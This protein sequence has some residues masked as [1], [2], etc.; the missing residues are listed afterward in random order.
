MCSAAFHH[1]G[2][3]RGY[4]INTGIKVL[5]EPGDMTVNVATQNQAAADADLADP[6]LVKLRDLIY[7]VSGIFHAESKFYLLA[8]RARRRMKELSCN[9]FADYVDQLTTRA[10]RDAEMRNL[11]NEITI[12]ETYFFRGQPTIDAVSKIIFPRIVSQPSKQVIKKLRI[13]SAGC[14]TGEESYTLSILF[15]EQIAPKFKDWKIEIL[16]TDLND[17][18]LAKCREGRYGEYSVRNLSPLMRDKYFKQEG[19]LYRVNEIVRAPIKF[20]RLN[21]QD[22]SKMLFMKGF[23]LVFCCNVLIYFDAA[24]KKRTVEHFYNGLVPGG[25]FFLG[26][27]ETLFGIY[28]QFHLV[29]FPGATGYYKPEPGQVAPAAK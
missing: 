26:E 20:D 14:S 2:R 18:S 29:H 27:C 9:T 17:D 15:L 28:E 8:I 16:A 4:E 6:A 22:Q 10:N 13:W 11:L 3:G 24:A 23:D 7:R 19:N 5:K 21:L 1:D 12:G 25:H